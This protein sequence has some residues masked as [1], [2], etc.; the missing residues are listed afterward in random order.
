M[1]CVKCNYNLGSIDLFPKT[2]LLK[3]SKCNQEYVWSD[4]CDNPESKVI[5]Y[6]SINKIFTQEE[7]EQASKEIK[8]KLVNHCTKQGYWVTKI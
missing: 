1:I 3:C 8:S 4:L 2:H 7:A 5:L 6:P